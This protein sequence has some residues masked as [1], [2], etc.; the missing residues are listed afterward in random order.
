MNDFINNGIIEVATLTPKSVQIGNPAYN[1]D[2][3][4]ELINDVNK[5]NSNGERQTRIVVFP[6][7]CITG[8]TCGDLFNH[9]TLINSAINELFRFVEKSN[10]EFNPIMFVGMPLRKDNQLFNCAIPIHKGK[11]LG[12]I[13]KTYIP[14]YSVFYESRN[15]KPSF[16]RI[17]DEMT[18]RGVTYPFTTNLLIEDEVSGAVIGTEVCEDL[19]GPIPVSSY[20]CL[21]GANIIVNLSA[22]NETIGKSDY[23]R[24]LVR[25][26]SARCMCGYIYAS[27]TS[28]ESTTDNAFSGHCIIAENGYV[29]SESIFFSNT[30]ITYGEID[31]EK[32]INDRT[33]NSSY[34][35]IQEK[36]EYK[37]INTKTF[38]PVSHKFKSNKELSVLPF[39]PHNID[40]RS[41]EIMNI[42]ITGLAQRLK[43][44]HC[45][46]AVIGISGGLDSTLALIVTVEAFKLNN[47]DMK[48][49]IG[50]TMPGFGT[51]SRTLENSKKLMEALN[52]TIL[53]IPIRDACIQ[54]Y[55]DIQHNIDIHDIT[56]E[57]GQARE[58]TQILM[59]MANKYNGIVVG[60]GDLSELALGWCT[61]NGDQMS[62]YGVNASIPKTL[63]RSIVKS[64]AK[65]QADDIK[66]TLLD[67]CDTPI[68][69]ELL[70]P[71]PDG[72]IAQKT[73]DAIGSYAVHDFVLYYMLRYGFGPKK[74][75]ELY[76]NSLEL[77]AVRKGVNLDIID[78]QSILRD[79]RT[80]Y[81]RFFAQQFKRSCMPDGIK[82]GSVSLSPRGDWRM[83]SDASAEIWLKELDTVEI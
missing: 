75:Y 69:P 18:I 65:K 40:S 31:I 17:N 1:V 59:D 6:E 61:Y 34:M 50:I 52:V 81:K 77:Q 79:M 21:H 26:H 19:W 82:V 12:I 45:S 20:H 27:A 68:S 62:M 23:R 43:K 66:D 16:D 32:C 56:Y 46:N 74:I 76:V 73:E 25:M 36:K 14:N 48:G 72:T 44:I 7:L 30:E 71:N 51:T 8:Y 24:D 57:N 35:I 4:L 42:Q 28:D 80:F 15:F 49:I 47:Y 13:P 60:T 78:K 58:R 29:I 67:I 37:C 5:K 38:E 83:P 11:I 55:N 70:P 53:E 39:V 63:V 22:S 64:Y 54:H 9:S 33:M 2:R 3:M 41:E 10:N